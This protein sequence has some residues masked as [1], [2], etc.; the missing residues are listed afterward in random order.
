MDNAIFNSILDY[1]SGV[2]LIFT[3]VLFTLF[4]AMAFLSTKKSMRYRHKNSF[5][6]VNSILGSPLAPGIT[7]IAPAYNEG[8]TIVENVRSLLSLRYVRY[9]VM[10]VNDGSK[11]DTLQK[12]I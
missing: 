8:L 11:D 6:S 2:F 5:G 12:L 9:E 4:T 10:V 7:I 3:V 1:I